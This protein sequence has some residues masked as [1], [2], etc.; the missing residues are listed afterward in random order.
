MYAPVPVPESLTEL[1]SAHA[2]TI[3]T[4]AQTQSAS[5]EIEA[6]KITFDQTFLLH[7]RL[8]RAAAAAAHLNGQFT[9][10]LCFAISLLC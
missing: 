10:K 1:K 5:G 7:A 2:K 6:K 4:A 9:P 3:K 8:K